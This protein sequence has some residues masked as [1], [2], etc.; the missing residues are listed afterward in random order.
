MAIPQ[1][2]AMGDRLLLHGGPTRA[3]LPQLPS[4]D[5][6]PK[7]RPPR[8]AEELRGRNMTLIAATGVVATDLLAI[9]A[10]TEN[11]W[12]GVLIAIISAIGG[13]V[14]AI[15][16]KRGDRSVKK[17]LMPNGG[18]TLR[19][20]IDRID[21]R[22]ASGFEGIERRFLSIDDRLN[23]LDRS[24]RQGTEHIIELADGAAEISL[25]VDRVNIDVA[26][27]KI[28]VRSL[29]DQVALQNER[30]IETTEHV[31]LPSPGEVDES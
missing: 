30:I 12:S 14:V 13:I 21:Q 8:T 3:H 11:F 10:L 6:L 9:I 19:D 25:K 4:G 20:A 23:T 2:S 26:K 31:E 28:Q 18:K 27:L 15:V 17:E 16:T 1:W 22:T 29:G 24:T 7:F 5:Q